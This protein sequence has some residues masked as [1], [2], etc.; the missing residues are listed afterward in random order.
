MPTLM[1]ESPEA[2]AEAVVLSVLFAPQAASEAMPREPE[3][4]TAA[5]L[6]ERRKGVSPS[7]THPFSVVG[8]HRNA[9]RTRLCYG[10]F[11]HPGCYQTVPP[12]G[13]EPTSASS[14]TGWKLTSK[15]KRPR[16]RQI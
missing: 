11:G 2:P 12:A 1:P 14:V 7:H 5:S 9:R 3:S 16:L 15:R 4:T 8:R 13:T 10:S 6:V